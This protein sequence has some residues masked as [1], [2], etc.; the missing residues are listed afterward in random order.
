MFHF[1]C[2][3]IE[4]IGL[5]YGNSISSQWLLTGHDYWNE[6]LEWKFDGVWTWDQ[7]VCPQVYQHCSKILLSWYTSN[8]N[9]TIEHNMKVMKELRKGVP[10]GVTNPNFVLFTKL[11]GSIS[12]FTYLRLLKVVI[13]LTQ[14]AA[15]WSFQILLVHLSP[16]QWLLETYNGHWDLNPV[17]GGGF[18]WFCAWAVVL[19]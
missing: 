4:K 8:P 15:A 2:S 17:K 6:K 7:C 9:G 12:V 18:D 16:P 14:Y 10:I 19:L 3:F 1:C 11:F 13:R 5:S